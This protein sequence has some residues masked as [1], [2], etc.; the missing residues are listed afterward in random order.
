VKCSEVLQYSDS[1]SNKV[2]N[3]ITRHVDNIKLLLKCVLLLTHSFISFR[4]YFLSMHIGLYSCLI[5]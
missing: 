3:I 2:S 1:L 4:F 5:L